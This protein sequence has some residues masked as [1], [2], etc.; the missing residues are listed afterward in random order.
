MFQPVI[1]NFRPEEFIPVAVKV[2]INN[3]K[4]GA[5]AVACVVVDGVVGKLPG[6]LAG[7]I[8]TVDGVA[9]TAPIPPIDVE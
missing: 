9:T 3:S 6:I 8:G 5:V 4:T 2:P 7:T 1:L